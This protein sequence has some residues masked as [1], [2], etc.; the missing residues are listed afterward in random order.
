[1]KHSGRHR[2]QDRE[3]H[4][5]PNL[6]ADRNTSIINGCQR[7]RLWRQY[8]YQMPWSPSRMRA[9]SEIAV[10]ARVG[11]ICRIHGLSRRRRC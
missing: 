5:Q 7:R 3:H 2:L 10:G 1:M 6:A 4:G 9:Q 8:R 11:R